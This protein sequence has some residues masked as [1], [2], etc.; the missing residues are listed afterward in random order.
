[1]QIIIL[2]AGLVGTSLA[3]NLLRQKHSITIIEKDPDRCAEVGE[4]LDALMIDGT[5]TSPV[6]LERAGIDSADMLIAATPVD[7]VNIIACMIARQYNVEH[8]IA[9]IRNQAFIRGSERINP[10]DFGITRIIYPEDHTIESVLHYIETPGAV[11]AQDFER[12][13]VFMRSYRIT[14]DMPIAGKSLLD[15][16]SESGD[17]FL[18]V[19]V[20]IREGEVII[21]RGDSFI[22]PGDKPLFVFHRNSLKYFLTLVDAEYPATRKAVIY[23]NTLTSVNIAKMVREHLDIVVFI[24]P[25]L[26]HGNF[27]ATELDGIDVLHGKGDDTDVLQEANVRFADYF[28]AASSEGDENILAALLAKSEG[29]KEAIAI[30]DDAQHTQLFQSIGIDHVVNPRQL[31]AAGILN[32]IHPGFVHSSVHIQK[33]DIDVL[34]FRVTEDCPIAGESLQDGWHKAKGKSVVG[35]V[36]RNEEIIVPKGS[37]ILTPGDLVIVFTLSSGIKM[38]N[39]LFGV[40]G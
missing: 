13:S 8:R 16:R 5:G 6:D 11:D 20:I 19:V 25:D 27:A 12:G 35:A 22:L 1:M 37:T 21:P 3:E 30:I 26:E 36:F 14:E 7:E 23:G 17:E 29:A 39:K 33:T 31:T 2:G 15:L 40:S 9:R 34:R 28:I 18:L 32:A 10:A 4:K 38:L 24:D